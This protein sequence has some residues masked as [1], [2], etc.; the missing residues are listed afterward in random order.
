VVLT[1]LTDAA[2]IVQL[3]FSPG[4]DRSVPEMIPLRTL[5]HR[6][7]QPEV[8]D[9]P[10]LDEGQHFHALRGLERINRWSFSARVLWAPLRALAAETPGR[11]VRVLDVATGAGDL[12][13]RLWRKARKAGVALRLD[14]CDVSIQALAFARRRAAEQQAD[15]SFFP[16]DV[17][18]DPLPA[19]YDVLLSSL[20]LHH[21]DEEPAVRLLRNMAEAAGRSVL[22]N[23]LERSPLNYTLVYAATRLLTTSRVV[24]IDGPLS[25]QAAFTLGEVHALARQAGMAGA[26]VAR[27]WPCRF[28]LNWKRP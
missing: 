6:R 23:D 7:R 8:M 18:N 5:R 11:P 20:F 16:L 14:G 3:F 26:T 15:V 9:Q 2:I 24:H 28:L 19:G 17:L 13:I 21:L 27:R 25:V 1:L 4:F 12:P 10:G 22:I